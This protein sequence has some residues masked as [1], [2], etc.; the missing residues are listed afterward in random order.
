M[1]AL[2]RGRNGQRLAA[3]RLHGGNIQDSVEK[4]VFSGEVELRNA[5]LVQ[6][7]CQRLAIQASEA[8]PCHAVV[9]QHFRTDSIYNVQ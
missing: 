5:S 6:D 9:I 1:A 2:R 7:S 3:P 4:A 8:P